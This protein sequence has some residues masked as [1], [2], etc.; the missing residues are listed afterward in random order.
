[1]VSVFCVVGYDYVIFIEYEDM[2]VLLDE[3]LSKVIF[4]LKGV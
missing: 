2:F 1:M 3:G 4:L